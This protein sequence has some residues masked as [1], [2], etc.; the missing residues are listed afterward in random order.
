MFQELPPI[1]FHSLSSMIGLSRSRTQSESSGKSYEWWSLMGEKLPPVSSELDNVGRR[2]DDYTPGM[3]TMTIAEPR[4]VLTR[5]SAQE[6]I[7][8]RESHDQV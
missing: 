6:M 4:E 8:V 5:G 2:F 1:Q 3:G 7:K